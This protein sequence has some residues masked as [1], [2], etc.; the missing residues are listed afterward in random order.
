[1]TDNAVEGAVL[2]SKDIQRF[3]RED[4]IHW[5][6]N[7]VLAWFAEH[8]KLTGQALARNG[9]DEQASTCRSYMARAEAE[10]VARS[11]KMN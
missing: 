10:L 6:P 7:E 8:M 2:L 9:D 4:E 3:I 11:G 1:M 5:V